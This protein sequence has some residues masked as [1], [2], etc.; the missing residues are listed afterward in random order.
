[1]LINQ[2]LL[3]CNMITLTSNYTYFENT[4]KQ[5]LNNFMLI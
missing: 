1:M 2:L 3:Q 5:A 4:R